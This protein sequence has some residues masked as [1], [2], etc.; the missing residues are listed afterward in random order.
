MKIFENTVVTITFELRDSDG[1]LLES[2]TEP[3]TYLHG[4]HSGMR[5]YGRLPIRGKAARYPIGRRTTC[6]VQPPRFS[7]NSDTQP[8]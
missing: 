3:I 7:A 5:W 1:V 8:T 4:G 6:A 2:A